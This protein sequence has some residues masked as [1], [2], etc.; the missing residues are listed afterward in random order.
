[1]AATT[2]GTKTVTKDVAPHLS[3]SSLTSLLAQP[4]ENLT[5]AKFYKIEDA[6]RRIA[7][8]HAE[9]Q[10]IGQLFA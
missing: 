7:S 3:A 5:V 10:T 1:M 9:S 6:L 8:G 4:I 2:S